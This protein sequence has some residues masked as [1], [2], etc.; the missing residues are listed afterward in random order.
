LLW[1]APDVADDPGTEAEELAACMEALGI[2]DERI[3]ELVREIEGLLAAAEHR[4]VI[5]QAKGVI[6][7]TARCSA[8]TDF[9]VLV[10]HSQHENRKLRNIAAEIAGR[11]ERPS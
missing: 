7:A 11:Q 5:E 6:M 10:A 9:A 1:Q 2:R 4:R 3:V 8:D